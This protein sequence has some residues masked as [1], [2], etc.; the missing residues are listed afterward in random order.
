MKIIGAILTPILIGIPLLIHASNEEAKY[1]KLLED[2]QASHKEDVEVINAQIKNIYKEIN[3][4]HDA[5]S[6]SS[7]LSDEMRNQM[8]SFITI[9]RDLESLSSKLETLVRAISKALV[10]INAM[11]TMFDDVTSK[12]SHMID[13]ATTAKTEAERLNARYFIYNELSLLECNWKDVYFKVM[14]LDQCVRHFQILY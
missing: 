6:N 3:M 12:L 11:K 5:M 2:T 14:N 9:D 13:V 4:L 7:S 1:I 10:G 8:K